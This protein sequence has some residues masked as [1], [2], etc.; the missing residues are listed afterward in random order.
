MS[1]RKGALFAAALVLL[2]ASGTYSCSDG[3][4][5][6]YSEGTRSGKIIK[7]S[8]KG[9]VWKS[10]EATMLM[11]GLDSRSTKEGTTYAPNLFGCSTLDQNI[12]KQLEAARSSGEPVSVVYSEYLIGPFWL[13]TSYEVASVVEEGR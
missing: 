1:S 11:E 9:I 2:V 13:G 6:G 10:W 3:I 4:M 7:L 8:L 5:P 12:A